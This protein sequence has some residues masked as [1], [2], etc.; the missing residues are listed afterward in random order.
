MQGVSTLVNE[1]HS[2]LNVLIDKLV[3]AGG[4]EGP[5]DF[6]DEERADKTYFTKGFFRMFSKCAIELIQD[7]GVFVAELLQNLLDHDE[8]QF[9]IVTSRVGLLYTCSIDALSRVFA[10]RYETNGRT[11]FLPPVLP[12]ELVKM[13]PF[14]FA[15]IVRLHKS[16]LKDLFLEDMTTKINLQ[17]KSMKDAYRTEPVLKTFLD[18]LVIQTSFEEGW[19]NDLVQRFPALCQF[20]GGLASMFPG[21]STLTMIYLISDGKKLISQ[22]RRSIS[23][24]K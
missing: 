3:E 20:V 24:S 7:Q 21:T 10:Q 14:D 5:D 11:D 4:T 16:R 8:S 9:R 2:R 13:R 1:Q 22:L 18:T 23:L 19:H 12:N 17:F 15:Q 6:T